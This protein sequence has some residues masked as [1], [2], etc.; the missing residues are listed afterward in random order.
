MWK[1]TPF[2]GRY[3]KV[4]VEPLQNGGIF[5]VT[6]FVITITNCINAVFDATPL[7]VSLVWVFG[8]GNKFLQTVPWLAYGTHYQ[9]GAERMNPWADPAVREKCL[10]RF[11]I[12]LNLCIQMHRDLPV[13]LDT[14]NTDNSN[15]LIKCHMQCNDSFQDYD[16]VNLFWIIAVR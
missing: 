4:F 2:M 13:H 15:T 12:V 6:F 5:Q 3:N 8:A 16:S 10:H 7:P 14:P 9:T 11:R 1:V